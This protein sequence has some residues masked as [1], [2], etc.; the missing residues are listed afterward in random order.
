MNNFRTWLL[1][2]ALTMLLVLIGGVIGGRS[3]MMLF[4]VF[5]LIIN[6]VSYYY[7]DKIAITMTRSK[8]VSES[9]APELYQSIRS[10]SSNAGIPM[11]RIYLT[12]SNQ[13]NAFATGRNPNNAVVAVTQ[14]LLNIMNRPE[15]DGVLAHEIAHVKNRDILIGSIAASIAGAI[16][17]LANMAR[18][19]MLFFGGRDDRNNAGGAVALIVVSILAP[20]AALIVQM[21]I[22]RSREYQ[23]DASGAQIAGNPMGLANALIKLDQGVKRIP[24]EVSPATAH[25]FIMNPLSGRSLLNLFSTHPSVESRV[26][27][28]HELAGTA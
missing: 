1:L 6:M 8:P 27:K 23:A 25:M 21:A 18:Y 4:F 15:L 9:E 26:K 5:A 20:I 12:P 2:G 17:M 24:M 10:L 16:M 3:G 11:P 22:S 7:S 13:P 14:G 19:S 28:L